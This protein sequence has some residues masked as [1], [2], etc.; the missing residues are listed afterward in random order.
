MSGAQGREGSPG[1]GATGHSGRGLNPGNKTTI[2]SAVVGREAVRRPI[3]GTSWTSTKVS[4]RD[5]A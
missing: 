1:A 2:D 4:G 5:Q 3:P